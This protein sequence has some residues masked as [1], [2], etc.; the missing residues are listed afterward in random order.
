MR[1]FLITSKVRHCPHPPKKQT[2][3]KDTLWV[4]T[5]DLHCT[6]QEPLTDSMQHGSLIKYNIGIE[7]IHY[8]S[9]IPHHTEHR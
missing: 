4:R 2:E 6:C 5:K 3:R 7:L 1:S 8:G 9:E